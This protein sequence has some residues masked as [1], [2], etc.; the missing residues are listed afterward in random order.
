VSGIVFRFTLLFNQG[1]SRKAGT[2]EPK[3]LGYKGN[4]QSTVKLQAQRCSCVA[5][6]RIFLGAVMSTLP[7]YFSYSR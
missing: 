2:P 5:P 4:F 7:S 3:R 1:Y 6:A